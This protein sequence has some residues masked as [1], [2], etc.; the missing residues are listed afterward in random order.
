LSINLIEAN[1]LTYRLYVP[2]AATFLQ[3]LQFLIRNIFIIL[4]TY[5]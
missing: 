1:A 5:R 3:C 2:Y 4:F